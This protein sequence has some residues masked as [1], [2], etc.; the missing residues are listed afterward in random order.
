MTAPILTTPRLT[1]RGFTEADIN[2]MWQIMA[3]KDVLRYF[4]DSYPPDRERVAT[5]T[6]RIIRHWEGHGYGLW[7]VQSHASGELIGRCGL[8]LIPETGEVE[9]DF[10]PGNPLSRSMPIRSCYIAIT[11]PDSNR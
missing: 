1:L 11:G 6:T 5:M 2:P 3:G 4:P 7:A 9:M 10:V 8:Q